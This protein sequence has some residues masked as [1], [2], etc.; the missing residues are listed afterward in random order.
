MGLQDPAEDAAGATPAGCRR[1][2]KKLTRNRRQGC[3]RNA[4]GGNA[5]ALA[6]SLNTITNATLAWAAAGGLYP[7]SEGGDCI[8]IGGGDNMFHVNKGAIGIRIDAGVGV[9]LRNVE[10]DTVRNTGR[11][12]GTLC[13]DQRKRHPA[14]SQSWYGNFDIIFG[15]VSRAFA[16]PNVPTTVRVPWSPYCPC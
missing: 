2:Q 6:T 11:P 12:V 9:D 1:H 16:A 15:T 10:I 13:P 5:D 8:V 14:Q 3:P 7:S 4:L